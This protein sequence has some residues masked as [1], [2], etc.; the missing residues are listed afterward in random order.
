[1]LGERIAKHGARVWLVNTGWTGGAYG[2][3]TRM[4]LSLTRAM[5][6]AA[7]SGS[8]D[9]GQ[10]TRDPVFGFEVPASVPDVPS[11]LL[12]P[13]S[14]WADPHA[15]DAQAKKLATMFKENFQQYRSEVPE[16]VAKA[17]PA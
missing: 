10:F 14:T 13:R 17:G 8:L 11:N 4:K 3:G 15:Y 12:S 2:T 16:S 9:K 1:M 6:R 7:L 5:L